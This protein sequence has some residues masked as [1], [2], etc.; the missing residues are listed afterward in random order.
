MA[1]LGRCQGWYI[2]GGLGE[3]I[4]D[5]MSCD[6]ETRA[7]NEVRKHGMESRLVF[8]IIRDRVE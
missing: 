4:P 2:F 7:P 6:A 8:D 5:C 1:E 3:R